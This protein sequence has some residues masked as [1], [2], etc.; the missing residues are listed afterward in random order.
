MS[1]RPSSGRKIVNTLSGTLEAAVRDGRLP[2][3]PAHG[4]KLPKVVLSRKMYLTHAQVMDLAEAT[5]VKLPGHGYSTLVRLLA[6]CGLRWSE[7]SGLRVGDVDLRRARLE[8]QRTVTEAG[9]GQHEGALK[10]HEVRSVPV[11]PSILRALTAQVEG[12]PLDLP[13]FPGSR[14]NGWLRNRVTRR[15]RSTRVRWRW[16]S[17][18]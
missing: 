17:M 7:V 12:R 10:S 5:D 2:S 15:A 6:Y 16:A 13:L 18:G 14:S 1:Q 4:L 8:V 9:G 3:N 11:P